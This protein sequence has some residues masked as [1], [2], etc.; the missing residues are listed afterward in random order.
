MDE[1]NDRLKIVEE[2]FLQKQIEDHSKIPGTWHIP[3]QYVTEQKKR[4]PS[5]NENKTCI[6]KVRFAHHC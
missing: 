5:G 1:L 6:G 4:I 2:A 3:V